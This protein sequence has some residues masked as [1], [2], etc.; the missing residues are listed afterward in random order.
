MTTH[1][2]SALTR[3]AT[4]IRRSRDRF[5]ERL[6]FHS[7]LV[8]GI[9]IFLLAGWPFLKAHLEAIAILQQV[10]GKPVP[11]LIGAVVSQPVQT[12]DLT[13]HVASGNVRAR[14][15][16][17]VNKPNAPALV[18]FHGVHHLGIDEPRLMAF[19]GA[20]ANCGIRVLTP[21]LPDIMDYHVDAASIV[22]IGQS[23][24]WWAR[25]TGGPVGVLGLSF[26]GGLALIAASDPAYHAD[27]KFVFAVGSQDSMARVVQ[28]YR[29]GAD[30]RPTGPEE[31]L[32]AH[33][34]GPLV[35]EYEYVQDF[36]PAPDV[37]AI[38][39]VLRA[40]LYEDKAA[41]AL[42][43][44]HLNAAQAAEAK[45][46]MN[47]ASPKTRAQ[48]AAA[49]IRHTADMDEL[50]PGPR[51]RTMTTPVYLLHG[52]ADNIIPSAETLWMATELPHETLQAVLV[53]RVIS[54]IDMDQGDPGLAEQW[55]LIHFFALIMH[56]IDTPG[57]RKPWL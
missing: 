30:L 5:R 15:Y 38:R 21:E 40:H 26:S 28:Y 11:A 2:T 32:P 7:L 33:E 3:L 55:R 51:L 18:V 43:E 14:T 17:P 20:M 46:L 10:S 48:I 29:T 56:A 49:S 34:Y 42:A 36:V 25:Q 54:H 50:S 47:A 39:P 22:T 16:I 52:E 6:V 37:A 23:T 9:L 12:Q 13:I 24:Q 57:G 8:A 1:R 45:E 41:E 35:I 4:T 53:S 27:F 31:I 44:S 19:A